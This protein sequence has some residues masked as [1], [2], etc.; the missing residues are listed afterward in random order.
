MI[1]KS[2][3]ITAEKN[4]SSEELKNYESIHARQI[5]ELIWENPREIDKRIDAIIEDEEILKTIF[6]KE[7]LQRIKNKINISK[8]I[9]NLEDKENLRATEEFKEFFIKTK[10][11]RLRIR[12]RIE[13]DMK[14]KELTEQLNEIPLSNE[15]QEKKERIKA[16]ENII[17]SIRSKKDLKYL[18]QWPIDIAYIY[19]KFNNDVINKENI[20]TI[21]NFIFDY[22]STNHT[23]KKRKDWQSVISFFENWNCYLRDF[24]NDLTKERTA[25]G[26]K[27][28]IY[29][30]KN[31]GKLSKIVEK[32]KVSIK[33]SLL[34]HNIDDT[35]LENEVLEDFIGKVGKGEIESIK[36][37]YYLPK[38]IDDM[39]RI[40]WIMKKWLKDTIPALDFD[41]LKIDNNRE[42]NDI[43][44]WDKIS[45]GNKHYHSIK[46]NKDMLKRRVNLQNDWNI[47]WYIFDRLIEYIWIEIVKYRIEK[48]KDSN[49]FYKWIKYKILKTDF[50]D[51][52][53]WWADFIVLLKL[54]W[55]KSG[56]EEIAA[57]DLLTS[58]T[59]YKKYNSQSTDREDV[60]KKEK[61]ENAEKLKYL[62]STYIQLLKESKFK[63]F[64]FKAI[65]R[66]VIEE[67]A[68]MTY[69][70]LSKLMKWKTE[71]IQYDIKKYFEDTKTNNISMVDESDY[72]ILK[73]LGWKYEDI[74][75]AS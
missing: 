27:I 44:K 51:D 61:I 56:K 25:L 63:R 13:E 11:E 30:E 26:K 59:K 2:R 60:V 54:P 50:L 66:D 55:D 65:K 47:R 62:H 10:N 4:K 28:T 32:K 49:S 53:Y 8:I 19:K 29:N 36:N 21:Y 73:I 18:L 70:L 58:R 1:N 75:M 46:V 3:E 37:N 69:I 40:H 34:G 74:D 22:I 68:K 16:C 35:E 14:Q 52:S 43:I 6:G 5:C 12:N 9:L 38:D 41:E 72:H 48:L 64:K 20:E 24:E 17:N 45:T 57:I 31:K 33:E 39:E 42:E 15:L 23:K 71:D 67:D 7:E